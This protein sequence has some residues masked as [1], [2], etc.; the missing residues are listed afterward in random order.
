MK[1]SKNLAALLLTLSTA[2]AG[3]PFGAG[4]HNGGSRKMQV[5]PHTEEGR[6]ILA[7]RRQLAHSP[8]TGDVG[9]PE[10]GFAAV[11]ES[12]KEMLVTSQD[13]FPADFDPPVGPNYGGELIRLANEPIPLPICFTSFVNVAG[14]HRIN[15]HTVTQSNSVIL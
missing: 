11:R 4:G 14:L 7:G 6:R 10:G 5:N 8:R 3:C 13:F 9:I 1:W 12:I 15:E 2:E